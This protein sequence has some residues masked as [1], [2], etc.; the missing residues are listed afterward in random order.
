LRRLLTI[1]LIGATTYKDM[2]TR[3]S[4][5]RPPKKGGGRSVPSQTAIQNNGVS[6]SKLVFEAY[7]SDRL[8][9][10]AV[11]DYLGMKTKH[12]PAFEKLLNKTHAG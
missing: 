4:K 6:F 5:E 7:K 9:S 12:I 10:A 3:W 1:G 8:S 11:S 2:Y